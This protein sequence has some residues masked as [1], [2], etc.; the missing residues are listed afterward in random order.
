MIAS[1]FF[2]GL[3]TG[4][5]HYRRFP[6]VALLFKPCGIYDLSLRHKYDAVPAHLYIVDLVPLLGELSFDVLAIL[7]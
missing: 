4:F 2:A 1:L 7:A 5:Q 6:A 3:A